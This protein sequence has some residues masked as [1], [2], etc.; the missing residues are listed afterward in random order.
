MTRLV[1]VPGGFHVYCDANGLKCRGN[2][3]S[4]GCEPIRHRENAEG[5]AAMHWR[6]TH[7]SD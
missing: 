5:F 3:I 1:E 7:G 6:I 2:L 4:W